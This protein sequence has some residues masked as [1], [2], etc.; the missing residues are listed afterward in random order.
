MDDA[1]E[2]GGSVEVT[3]T[4]NGPALWPGREGCQWI[5]GDARSLAFCGAPVLARQD[6]SRSSWCAT[7]HALCHPRQRPERESNHG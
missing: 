5:E 1:G 3:L 6:G 7:H 4:R 2:D